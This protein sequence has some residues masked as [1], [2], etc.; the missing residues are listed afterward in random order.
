MSF[1]VCLVGGKQRDPKKAKNKKRK[2]ELVLAGEGEMGG[3]KKTGQPLN[4]NHGRIQPIGVGR[5][6]LYSLL[7][8]HKGVGPFVKICSFQK[9][10][11]HLFS[12]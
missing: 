10:S 7:S 12:K 3:A 1:F 9:G 4:L 11:E 5:I 8:F 2:M 6:E